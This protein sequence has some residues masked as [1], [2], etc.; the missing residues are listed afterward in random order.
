M[1]IE[2]YTGYFHDGGL[3]GVKRKENNIE[4]F[5]RSCEIS[6][7]EP[8]DRKILSEDN[9]LKGKLCLEGVKWIKVAN[10]ENAEIPWKDYDDGEILDLEIDGNKVF[11]LIE[12][13][14]WPPKPSVRTNDVS[15]IEIE[16]EK[17]YWENI[18][19][20]SDDYFKKNK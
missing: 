10:N 18:P 7:D 5:L 12:W 8:I 2:K 9:A 20:L 17:I 3:I 15:K 16:A 14:N 6:L 19:N 1:N 11:L 13:K 4:L